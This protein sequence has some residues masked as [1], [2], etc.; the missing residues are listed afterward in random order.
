MGGPG[1]A[2]ARPLEPSLARKHRVLVGEAMEQMLTVLEDILLP[3]VPI[4]EKVL[5]SAIIYAF[6]VVLLRFA[7]ERTLAQMNPFDLVVL[8]T[9]S[10]AVQN[11]IIGNDN[12][13][14]GG[15]VGAVTLVGLNSLVV[16]YLYRHPDI[17]R[18]L[19]GDPL[20]LVQDG[21][22]LRQNLER[23]F[24]TEEELMAIMR[25]QGAHELSEVERVVLETSGAVSV[26]LR[27]PTPAESVP[28]ELSQR[29]DRIE[30][31][32]RRLVQD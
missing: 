4:V 2:G 26:L 6:L 12:S 11:A 10:N 8:L 22:I 23:A 7:G 19:E 28:A 14:V 31:M 32:L 20:V 17:E 1:C 18:R 21:R 13:L 5:R 30:G 9:L 29:L 24:I 27:H 15:M 25:R 3:G 16:R